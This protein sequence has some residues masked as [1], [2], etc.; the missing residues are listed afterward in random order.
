MQSALAFGF[1]KNVNSRPGARRAATA[2]HITGRHLPSSASSS[3]LSSLASSEGSESDVGESNG[4]ILG[5]GVVSPAAAA[6]AAAAFGASASSINSMSSGD[7]KA[8]ANGQRHAVPSA[9]KLSDA[10]EAESEHDRHVSQRASA[11]DKTN[12]F[13]G[14]FQMAALP[15]RAPVVA[16]ATTSVG[17]AAANATTALRDGIV[18]SYQYSSSALAQQ[19]KRLTEWI[20]TQSTRLPSL[21]S[22]RDGAVDGA[23]R[24]Q[25]D[26]SSAQTETTPAPYVMNPPRVNPNAGE[27]KESSVSKPANAVASENVGELNVAVSFVPPPRERRSSTASSTWSAC[28]SRF[29]QDFEIVSTLGQGG[30]GM[31]Y[32]VRSKVDGCLYAVKKVVLPRA[33]QRDAAAL[34]QAL[35]EVKAMAAMPPHANVVRYHTAWLEEES[36]DPSESATQK[37]SSPRAPSRGAE[38]SQA[39]SLAEESQ[40]SASFFSRND[41]SIDSL[42]RFEGSMCAFDFSE[43]SQDNVTDENDAVPE[44]TKT[45]ARLSAVREEVR[46]DESVS[47]ASSQPETTL[48]L[49]IQMELCSSTVRAPAARVAEQEKE[50]DDSFQRLIKRLTKKSRPPLAPVSRSISSDAEVIHST[51]TSWLRSSV[52]ERTNPDAELTKHREGLKLF[53]G[54]V[55]GVQHM[56]STGVIHRDLKPDNIFI[57]GDDAKIGDFG[58]SKSIFGEDSQGDDHSQL[59]H[60]PDGE[61]HTTALGTFTYASPEQLGY[62]WNNAKGKAQRAVKTAKY[63]TESDIFALGII[64]LE[65]CYPCSTMMERSQ[66]LTGVRHGVVPQIALQRFPNEMA[67]VLRMTATDPSERPST[68]EIIQQ[69]NSLAATPEAVTVR[70]ALEDLRELQ[71]KLAVA[72]HQLRDRSQ[73]AQQ[74]ELLVSELQDK[75][76]TVGIA[77]A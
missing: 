76:Q 11:V 22:R 26:K 24:P 21:F 27:V 68:T 37:G 77:L 2:Y 16:N 18:G 34:H 28:S 73:A 62:H 69:I 61:D 4:S 75:V 56:H 60:S 14:Y 7:L 32:K 31:V 33:L 63:S 59:G 36:M 23:T 52:D 25:D 9:G 15:P 3:S 43:N 12:P 48:V 38:V 45:Q 19:H 13:I 17:V 65:L 58:L 71:A 8:L 1:A 54:V 50:D 74:L 53:L 42:T 6:A 67:L 30:Q 70:S 5:F 66:V 57:H 72:V 40:A 64:L 39:S 20:G 29:E 44:T 35:R 49:Y 55:K 10:N 46:E 41:Y 51:L 47:S